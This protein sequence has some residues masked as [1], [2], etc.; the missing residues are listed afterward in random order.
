MWRRRVKMIVVG[1]RRGLLGVGMGVDMD[2][3]EGLF[4]LFLDLDYDS[5]FFS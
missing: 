5:L 1:R 2:W 3:W 4:S